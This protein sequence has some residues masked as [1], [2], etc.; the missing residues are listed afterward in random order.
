LFLVASCTLKVSALSLRLVKLCHLPEVTSNLSCH[1]PHDEELKRWHWIYK[2]HQTTNFQ[3][4]SKIHHIIFFLVVH[5]EINVHLH[6]RKS[7][8]TLVSKV[9]PLLR[10]VMGDFSLLYV[11]LCYTK[12][13]L[14]SC[15]LENHVTAP[16]LIQ[17][18]LL[19]CTN[20]VLHRS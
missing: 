13:N 19:N 1:G 5:S 15:S 10:L 18:S 12:K 17:P 2:T 11:K 7:G 4:E 3:W 14:S 16:R 8:Y 20:S 9:E 6:V